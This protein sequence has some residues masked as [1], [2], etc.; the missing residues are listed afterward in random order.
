MNPF[1]KSAQHQN[2]FLVSIG[3]GFNQLPLIDEARKQRYHVIGVD[4]DS[5]AAGFIKCDIKIQ[6]SLENHHD[7]YLKLRELLIDGQIKAVLS[8]SYGIAVRTA[9]Y[10][11]NQLRIP[12]MPFERVDQ[13]INKRAMKEA[14]ARNGIVTPQ[15]RI[16][17]PKTAAARLRKEPFPAIIKPVV[18]HAK[19][20]V[21][22]VNDAAALSEFLASAPP[23]HEWI[24]EEFIDGEEII[25]V[26]I[27]H[28]K[29]FHLV[30]ASDKVKT[31]PPHFVDIMHVA[32]SRHLDRR[33][34]ICEIGQRLAEAFDMYT[35][36]L[37]MELI[38]EPGKRLHLIEAVPEFGGEYLADYLIPT[39][40]GYN[41]FGETIRAVS[42]TGFTPPQLDRARGAVAVRYITGTP[43]TLASF[44]PE[45]PKGLRDTVYSRIFREVGA[46]VKSP[47]SNHDRIGVV[48]TKGKTA[49]EAV[50]SA[51]R[52]EESFNLRII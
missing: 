3:A 5:R 40:T 42:D 45:N 43:G 32:P 33:R 10:I 35:T 8:R 52:A 2:T 47:T 9:C 44:N 18:G 34:E 30:E 41:L 15:Y 17:T 25:A 12:M 48:I 22:R 37:V 7:I 19:T 20:N 38:A 46:Q 14:F 26:G 50:E 39:H 28:K 24:L 36:P 27:V 1:K 4:R 21:R 51:C 23:D 29:R 16:I 13:C 49:D 11:A 31:N 6:E